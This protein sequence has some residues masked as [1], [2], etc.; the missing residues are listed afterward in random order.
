MMGR[1]LMPALK[2]G[3]T[4]NQPIIAERVMYADD[5]QAAIR[6]PSA[7]VIFHARD[8]ILE[9]FDLKEDRGEL[10][11]VA[12]KAPFFHSLS[13]ELRSSLVLLHDQRLALDRQETGKVIELDRKAIEELEQLGY[14]SNKSVEMEPPKESPVER[15]PASAEEGRAP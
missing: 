1:S 7:N 12:W 2:T 15:W 5:Y 14:I 3:R 8:R 10:N 13:E 11:D 9:A 4:A 6:T